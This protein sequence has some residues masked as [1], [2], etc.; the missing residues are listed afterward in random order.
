MHFHTLKSPEKPAS[1]VGREGGGVVRT[2][3]CSVSFTTTGDQP[4]TFW[5]KFYLRI[6]IRLKFLKFYSRFKLVW[7]VAN[8][9]ASLLI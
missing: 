4:V 7:L 2:G 9:F 6:F 8:I 5:S 3:D 1:N